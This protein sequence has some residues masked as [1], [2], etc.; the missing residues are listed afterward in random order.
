M[1]EALQNYVDWSLL[2]I[3]TLFITGLIIFLVT[4]AIWFYIEN[5]KAKKLTKDWEAKQKQEKQ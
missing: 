1:K 2:I 5:E 3:E 4:F